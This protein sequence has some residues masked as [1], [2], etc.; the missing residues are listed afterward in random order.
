MSG[1]VTQSADDGVT[2]IRILM[3]HSAAICSIVGVLVTSTAIA[4]AL[5]IQVNSAHEAI[6]AHVTEIEDTKKQ[7]ANDRERINELAQDLRYIRKEMDR[8]ITILD[9]IEKRMP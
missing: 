3:R 5:Q 9:K 8:A 7:V 2:I 4:T 1:E 6:R